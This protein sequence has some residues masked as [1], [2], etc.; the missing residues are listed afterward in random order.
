MFVLPTQCETL[1]T[2]RSQPHTCPWKGHGRETCAPCTWS[3]EPN[4]PLFPNP[5]T[6]R[7]WSQCAR[8]LNHP[9]HLV[10][11]HRFFRVIRRS[12]KFMKILGWLMKKIPLFHYWW[13][14]T[15]TPWEG[16]KR[17]R[18]KRFAQEGGLITDWN[19]LGPHESKVGLWWSCCGY[20]KEQC[21][22]GVLWDPGSG[23]HWKSSSSVRLIT[24]AI[25]VLLMQ[26]MSLRTWNLSRNLPMLKGS[27]Q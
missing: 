10:P 14:S 7:L 11:C 4:A 1:C 24:V 12:K 20:L 27:E 8:K 15:L 25:A 18:A 5:L 13:T 23:T 21:K 2:Q 9:L 3:V 19:G 22:Q 17:V 26:R 6:A 16:R